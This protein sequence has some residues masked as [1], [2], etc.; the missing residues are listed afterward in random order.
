MCSYFATACG[1]KNGR[2]SRRCQWC[3]GGSLL[4]GGAATPA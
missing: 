4:M 3:S 2:M 1:A